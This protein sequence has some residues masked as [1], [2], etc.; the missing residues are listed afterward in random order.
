M[1]DFLDICG[2]HARPLLVGLESLSS[3]DPRYESTRDALRGYIT[4]FTEQS[5]LPER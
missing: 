5:T 4:Q 2:G 3:D 1:R